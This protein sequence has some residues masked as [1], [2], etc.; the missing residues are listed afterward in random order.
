MGKRVGSAREDEMRKERKESA[1]E[2]MRGAEEGE[3]I[4]F[5]ACLRA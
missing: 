4:F 5:L 1:R 2:M 3:Q